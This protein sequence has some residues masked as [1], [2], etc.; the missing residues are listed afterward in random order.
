M[1]RVA[2]IGVGPGR[3]VDISGRA[4]SWAYYHADAYTDRDD[5]EIVACADIVP[6]YAEAFAAEF[7]VPSEGVFEDHETMLDAAAPDVV[8]VCTPIPTHADIVIDCATAGVDAVHC[9]KP[10]A[11]TWGE[12]RAMAQECARRDVQL[13]FGHQRRFGEPYVRAKTLLDDGRIGDLDRIEISYG[14]FFDNGTHTVDLAGF[15]NDEHRAEWV[16]GQLDYSKEHVRYGVHTADHA[17]VSWMYENGV[18][19]VLATGDDVDLSGGPYDFYDVDM[20]LVGTEGAIEIN[21]LD[22]PTL[23][24]RRDGEGWESYD[25]ADELLGDIPAA[26]DDVIESLETGRESLVRAELALN[27]TEILFAGHESMRRR[28]RVDLPLTGVYDHPL[29]TMVE[30]GEV[31]PAESDDRPGHPGG[32]RAEGLEE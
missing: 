22:G 13:T 7:D 4:H 25:V 10:M 23:R 30:S 26:I 24:L 19:G 15:F 12:A 1:H 16:M 9:E 6:E 14:N 31:V 2:V 29:E 20:R 32:R 21:R 27:A 8:S 28:G 18:H 17:F 5:C 3:D 11:R